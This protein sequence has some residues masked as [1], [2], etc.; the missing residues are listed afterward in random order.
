MCRNSRIEGVKGIV[1]GKY[2]QVE[3]YVQVC[4]V[5]QS[6]NKYARVFQAAVTKEEYAVRILA[7][8]GIQKGTIAR[9]AMALVHETDEC[10]E[11]EELIKQIEDIIEKLRS[12]KG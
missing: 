12:E 2:I 8:V 9:I 10:G 11:S 6:K 3:G 5:Q 1:S 7:G 4:G